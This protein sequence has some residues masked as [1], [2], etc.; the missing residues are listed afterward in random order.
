MDD[1]LLVSGEKTQG[2][3]SL[4]DDKNS[5][6]MQR[7]TRW[8]SLTDTAVSRESGWVGFV[9]ITAFGCLRGSSAQ[10]R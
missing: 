5:Q 8:F 3:S 4:T 7:P 2:A 1:N 10:V 9:H 6:Q